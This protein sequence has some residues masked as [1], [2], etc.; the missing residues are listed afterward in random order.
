[1]EGKTLLKK[2]CLYGRKE[3]TYP[4]KGKERLLSISVTEIRFVVLYGHQEGAFIKQSSI[5][6][7]A[8]SFDNEEKH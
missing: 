3:L 5:S 8:E 6:S 7:A 1:M 2:S 4:R